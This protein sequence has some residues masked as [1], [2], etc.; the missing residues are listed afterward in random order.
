MINKVFTIYEL[1]NLDSLELLLP[2]NQLKHTVH[3]IIPR[4]IDKG[5]LSMPSLV[6]LHEEAPIPIVE[7]LK[8]SANQI[9]PI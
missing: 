7:L 2:R 6:R 1:V 3:E 8:Q 5:I 4:E 9:E